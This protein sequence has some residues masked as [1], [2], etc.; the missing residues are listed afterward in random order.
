MRNIDVSL[1]LTELWQWVH[2]SEHKLNLIE[3]QW[4]NVLVWSI[5]DFVIILVRWFL[6][7]KMD[8]THSQ[9]VCIKS[10]TC[11]VECQRIFGVENFNLLFLVNSDLL[12]IRLHSSLVE[13]INVDSLFV[14]DIIQ[15]DLEE[16]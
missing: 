2:E 7:L 14:I 11:W 13:L 10:L 15:L 9:N 6:T 16:H 12:W 3:G 1:G 8:V 5:A 4:S